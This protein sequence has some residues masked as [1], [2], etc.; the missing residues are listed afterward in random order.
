MYFTARAGGHTNQ[1]SEEF[2][3]TS[4]AEFM[5]TSAAEFMGTS[6]TADTI[7]GTSIVRNK[8]AN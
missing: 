4:A 7:S 5:G 6:A 3:G 8:V 2:M 1:L